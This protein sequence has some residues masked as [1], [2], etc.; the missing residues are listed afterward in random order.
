MTDEAI[1]NRTEIENVRFLYMTGEINRQR[2]EELAKP[3]IER[4][5]IKAVEVAKRHKKRPILFNFI[6]LMR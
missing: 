5:N 4:M 3:V 1:K 2:A 6:T